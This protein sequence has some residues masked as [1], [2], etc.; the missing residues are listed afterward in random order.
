[1]SVR[2]ALGQV[3]DYGRFVKGAKLSVLLPEAPEADLVELLEA[4]D[5]GCIVETEPGTFID[6]TSL[7]RCP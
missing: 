7:E 3:L 2:L 6:M 1:M 4:H 5:V